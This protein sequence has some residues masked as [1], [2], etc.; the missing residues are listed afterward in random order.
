MQ[1][2]RLSQYPEFLSLKKTNS[3]AKREE[4]VSIKSGFSRHNYGKLWLQQTYFHIPG[5]Q[6][7][8]KFSFFASE[9]KSEFVFKSFEQDLL[10]FALAKLFITWSQRNTDKNFKFLLSDVSMKSNKFLE[11]FYSCS[12]LQ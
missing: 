3:Q 11:L 12:V 1:M 2:P 4:F 8:L 5:F 7:L 6:F 9:N 10:L